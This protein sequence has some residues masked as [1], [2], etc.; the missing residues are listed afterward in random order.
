MAINILLQTTL[1]LDGGALYTETNLNQV[2]KEPFNTLSSVLF[3]VIAVSWL[4]RLKGFSKQ[5]PYLSF[6]SWILLI[7]S[8]G[9]AIYHAFRIHPFFIYMDWVPIFVLCVSASIYFWIKALGKWRYGVIV[10]L[11]FFVIEAIIRN[12]MLGGKPGL[13][14]NLNYATLALMI[15]V[16]VFMLLIKTAWKNAL[17]IVLAV[18]CF[19]AALFFRIAD[20]WGYLTTGTHFLWHIFGA[21]ATSLML[22]YVYRLNKASTNNTGKF[23]GI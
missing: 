10:L 7:G 19:V 6:N 14:I 15:V 11:I 1:P 21:L 12:L 22:L 3:L 16:P 17:L 2:I 13:A 9:G 18:L 4:V 5:H 23:I 8:I 20:G